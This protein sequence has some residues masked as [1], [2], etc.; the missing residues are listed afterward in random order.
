MKHSFS[1][2]VMWTLKRDIIRTLKFQD[3]IKLNIN[4]MT[5]LLFN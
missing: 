1:E 5:S 4:N 3:S 2:T